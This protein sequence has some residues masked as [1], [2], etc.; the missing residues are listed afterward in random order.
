MAEPD[1]PKTLPAFASRFSTEEA[2]AAF[3][4]DLPWPTGF[5]CPRCGSR[6]GGN[7]LHKL[8]SALVAPGRDRLHGEVE[9][10]E[11]YVGGTEA[12]RPGRGAITKALVVCAVEL[13]RWTDSKSGKSRVRTGRVRLRVLP[14]ASA[15]S[16]LPFAQDSVQQGAIVHTDGWAGYG[17]LGGLGYEHRSVTQGRGKDAVHSTHVHRIFSSLTTWLLGTHHGR[18]EKHHLQA[19][20]NEFTFR[21]NRRFWRRPAIRRALELAV[22][23]D[24]RPTYRALYGAGEEQGWAHPNSHGQTE[25]SDPA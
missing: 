2:C 17:A 5:V 16:L 15:E 18:V 21:F 20:L 1:F 25:S 14:D 12:G 24:D 9:I 10:D 6:G 11:A 23:A 19:Y 8:R 13:V 22:Q 3:L 4:G 7:M